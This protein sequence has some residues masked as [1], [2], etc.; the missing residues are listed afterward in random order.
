MNDVT[1]ISEL[2]VRYATAVDTRDWELFR[3][4]FTA[5]ALTDYGEVGKWNDSEEIAGFMEQVHVGFGP[6]NHM[7][8]NISVRVDG[9][10]ATS[11]AY[12]HAVL[13]FADDPG[14]IDCVGGYEDRLVRTPDGWRISNRVFRTTRMTSSADSR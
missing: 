6:T 12:V 1:A 11:T 8:S 4:C 2:L 9:D 13:T 7:L 5:D 14:W 10:E 3:R